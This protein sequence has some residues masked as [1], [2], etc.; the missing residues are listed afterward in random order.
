MTSA[1][2]S[3]K[4]ES[5]SKV[6]T[7]DLFRV[8]HQRW[9]GSIV[10]IKC[11]NAIFVLQRNQEQLQLPLKLQLLLRPRNWTTCSLLR[12]PKRLTSLRVRHEHSTPSLCEGNFGFVLTLCLL[13][14]RGRRHLHRQGGRRPHPQCEV[15]EGQVEADHARWADLHRA[16]RP[17]CQT[18]DQGG[19]QVRLGSVQVC[20]LQ[21]T[22]RD[23][24]QRRHARGRKE[25]GSGAGGRPPGQTEEVS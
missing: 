22:R 19:D 24:V 15:D 4:P 16:E 14:L 1:A 20:R 8:H 25:G 7:A 3:A 21:Q 9:I 10:W 23:R 12:N 2:S 13:T 18:G 17:G 5:Q 11:L 6:K